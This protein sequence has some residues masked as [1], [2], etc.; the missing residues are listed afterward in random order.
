MFVI[1]FRTTHGLRRVVYENVE[2]PQ[3]CRNVL[4]EGQHGWNMAEIQGVNIQSIRPLLKVS[5]CGISPRSVLRK[6]GRDVDFRAIAQKFQSCL[7]SNLNSSAREQRA[8]AAQIG[9][10]FSHPKIEFGTSRTKQMIKRM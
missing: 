5:F 8:S 1:R 6:A 4:R 3:V 2:M 7:K 9:S 10:L